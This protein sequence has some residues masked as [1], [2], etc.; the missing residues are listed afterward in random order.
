MT[1][2]K[3][4]N[5]WKALS[6]VQ[7]EELGVISES[8]KELFIWGCVGFCGLSFLA[9]LCGDPFLPRLILLGGWLLGYC[10]GEIA[11]RNKKMVLSAW[12]MGLS[13]WV[14]FAASHWYSGGAHFP[15]SPGE[16]VAI[17]L[18]G[19]LG[20]MGLTSALCVLTVLNALIMWQALAEG[21]APVAELGQTMLTMLVASSG[22]II[23]AGLG[24]GATIMRLSRASASEQRQRE[25]SADLAENFMGLF[26][27][28]PAPMALAELQ[29][30]PGKTKPRLLAVNEAFESLFETGSKGRGGTPLSPADLWE[31]A[32][33]FFDLAIKQ[34]KESSLSGIKAFMVSWS[35]RRKMI[36][37]A[38][39]RE[40]FWNGSAAVLW[41]FQ[42]VTEIEIIQNRLLKQNKQLAEVARKTSLE[43]RTDKLTKLPNRRALEERLAIIDEDKDLPF[44]AIMVD[45]DCFKKY[46]D[47]L[48]HPA[49]DAC[50]EKIGQ[51]IKEVVNRLGDGAFGARYGGE[52]F[53]V[54]LSGYDE[55]GA[56]RAAWAICDEVRAMNIKHPDNSASDYVTVSVGVS[57]RSMGGV[58]SDAFKRADEALYTS[59]TEGRARAS[60]KPANT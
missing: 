36:V 49:G 27:Q 50:L 56:M 29:R 53:S 46:N 54:A 51:A 41:T 25:K 20:G 8:L 13:S 38:S 5:A 3:S 18:G 33:E 42:D 26:L 23:L 17:I 59:K 14:V 48:G 34:K 37:K 30:N 35:S 2:H 52:E 15:V 7:Q 1:N 12:L 24:V 40:S 16:I 39:A 10:L 45:V 4:S 11:R 31:D 21:W 19:V 22:T 57:A 60:W 28:S 9:I 32:Q 47:K 43:A 58:A 55:A 44:C 6:E